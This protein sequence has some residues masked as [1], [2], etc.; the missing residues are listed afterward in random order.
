M[1][2]IIIVGHGNFGPGLHSALRLLN[3]DS[4]GVT[5]LAFSAGESFEKLCEKIN[6]EVSKNGDSETIILTDIP[7]GSPF[8]AAAMAAFGNHNVKAITGTNFPLLLELELGKA[9]AEDA[10]SLINSAL[11]NAKETMYQ[12]QL[13][14]AH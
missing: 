13:N 1:I 3:G 12:V 6:A 8:K 2:N 11:N 9:F 14:P 4:E 5:S 7:G 10:E